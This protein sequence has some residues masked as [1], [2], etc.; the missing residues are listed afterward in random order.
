MLLFCAGTQFDNRWMMG[1]FRN[2]GEMLSGG[3]SGRRM[4]P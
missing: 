3:D 1:A 4:L 2:S